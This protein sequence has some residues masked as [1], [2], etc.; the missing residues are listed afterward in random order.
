MEKKEDVASHD[1]REKGIE[2]AIKD[3]EGLDEFI[4]SASHSLRGPLATLKGLI[5]LLELKLAHEWE[6]EFIYTKMRVLG[7]HLDELLHK[8]IYYAES[9]KPHEFSAEEVTLNEIGKRLRSYQDWDNAIHHMSFADN[10]N[11]QVTTVENGG[12]ILAL[13]L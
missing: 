11:A 9:D 2:D 12:L 4:Y 8:L 1:A 7:N 13:L 5:N 10:L 6:L 3:R